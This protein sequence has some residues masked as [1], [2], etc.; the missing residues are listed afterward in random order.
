MTNSEIF[1]SKTHEFIYSKNNSYFIGVTDILIT[2]LGKI[3]SVQLPEIGETYTKG[4]IFAYIESQNA[5]SEL[6]MP[7]TGTI[8]AI[9]NI[10]LETPDK[11][12]TSSSLEEN[13]LVM[14]STDYFDEDK[15]DLI[16]YNEY[17]A[18]CN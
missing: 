1:C 14:I 6:F 18:E 13:W 2:K 15:K 5:A 10:F 4:E 7:V 17:K 11:L 9:N 8:I 12:N 16:C 3:Q